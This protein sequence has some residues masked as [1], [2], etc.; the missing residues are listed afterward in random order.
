MFI[1]DVFF[2]GGALDAGGSVNTSVFD[3]AQR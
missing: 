1:L 3:V 2:H